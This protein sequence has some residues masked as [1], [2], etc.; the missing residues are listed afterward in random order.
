[1]AADYQITLDPTHIDA[2]AA[3]AFL[4]KTYWSPG[5]PLSVVRRA[6]GGSVCVAVRAEGEQ[7]AFARAVT[8][9]AT[10]AYL[11]DV[12]VLEE[13]RGRGLARKMVE[14]LLGHPDLQGLRRLMLATRDAHSLYAKFG[15]KPLANPARMMELLRADP[16]AAEGPSGG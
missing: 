4:S 2:E 12:Y 6:I 14:A 7:V 11:A 8:D 5:I 10:F 9:R 15:F 3:H 13:H 16:Y 1:M